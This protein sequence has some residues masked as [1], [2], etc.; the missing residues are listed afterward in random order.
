MGKLTTTL[1]TGVALIALSA[2]PA[3]AGFPPVLLAKNGI[4]GVTGTVHYKTDIHNPGMTVITETLPSETFTG[5]HSTMYK[6]TKNL[7]PGETWLTLTANGQ[8]CYDFTGS[9]GQKE[10]FSK[11]A[12]AKIAAYTYKSAG[13]HTYFTTNGATGHCTGTLTLY[14]PA[15]EL[16]SKIATR[17][18]FDGYDAVK[19]TTTTTT[20]GTKHKKKKHKFELKAKEPW[21][22]NIK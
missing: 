15:Y 16:K 12:N 20:T 22:I 8:H 2:A 9:S 1:L 13:T 4:R 6:K 17:D 7:V 10:S 5:N 19:F 11:D 21:T 18:A 3:L 14:A